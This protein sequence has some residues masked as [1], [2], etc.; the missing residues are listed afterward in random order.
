M[1]TI[2]K[3]TRIAL[4][5][6]V[7]TGLLAGCGDD[8]VLA[9]TGGENNNEPPPVVIKTPKTLTITKISVKGF[10]EK[11]DGKYWD[12]D[13][14][15][16][17]PRRADI[18][19]SLKRPGAI[20]I[21]NSDIRKNAYHDK[22]YVFT[23]PYSS[24]DGH[25]PRVISYSESRFNIYL[26]D[27]DFGGDTTMGHVDVKPSSL[28]GKDNAANFSKTVTRNGVKIKIHGNWSY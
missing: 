19:V 23:E 10:P 24:H 7:A 5:T 17:G 6:L 3:L 13:P 16:S 14:I 28:Y 1:V 4:L 2:I 8:S 18:S 25:L 21:F 9:P 11:N 20:P 15:S 26:I 12:W 22:T 27:D